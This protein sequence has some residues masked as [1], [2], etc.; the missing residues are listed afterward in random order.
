MKKKLMLCTIVLA[1]VL[2]SACS[3]QKET[4]NQPKE[5]G[6]Q[7]TV[8]VASLKG[9]TSMGLVGLRKKSDEKNASNEYTFEMFAAADELV[10]KIVKNE[11]DIALVPANL[12][13][14][15]CKKTKGKI[16][17]ID[18]NT[19]GVL[20]VVENGTSIQTFSDLKGKTI[21]MTGKGTT[22]EYALNYLLE[23]NGLSRE[24]VTVEF[25]SEATE[26]VAYLTSNQDSIG[27]LPQPFVTG[28]TMQKKELRVA[29]NFSEVWE[30]ATADSSLVTGVTIVRNE[31]LE[32][33]ETT[34]QTFLEEHKESV[35]YVN[36]NVDEASTY[37]EAYEIVKAPIAKGA[38]PFCNL[39]C[40][41]GE[42]M[43]TKLSGY[44]QTLYDANPEAVGGTLP[45]E[46]FYY[47]SSK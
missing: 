47:T 23:M 5:E 34:V 44:L 31:F 3:K 33:H 10:T 18:I 16:S 17:A 11:V 19:L 26:V 46:E 7:T 28:A 15:L 14:I 38:I 43:K 9:P 13:S 4:K 41:T 40:I 42:D 8:R 1:M 39:V 35:S 32:Q 36:D 30:E 12:A 21:C 6:N 27:I 2:L 22:P 37:V 24:D 29:L 25:K 45:D 20:S